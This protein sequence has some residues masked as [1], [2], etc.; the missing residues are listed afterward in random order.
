MG[1]ARMIQEARDQ[2]D[3]NINRE[4]ATQRRREIEQ[5]QRRLQAQMNEL[6]TQSSILEEE[7]ERL[8]EV[9]RIRADISMTENGRIARFR[10]ADQ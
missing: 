8:K 10:G 7:R 4:R 5:A 3:E 2:A 1:S 9:E 6:M